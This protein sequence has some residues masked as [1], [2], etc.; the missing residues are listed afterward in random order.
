VDPVLLLSSVAVHDAS[1]FSAE[2]VPGYVLLTLLW[3]QKLSG[4]VD[5]DTKVVRAAV[6]QIALIVL[7]C[8]VAA[9]P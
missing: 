9:G 4:L 7:W 3:R 1:K 6:L 5:V 8:V 2:E